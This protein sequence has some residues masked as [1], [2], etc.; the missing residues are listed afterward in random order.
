MNIQE[1]IS[2]SIYLLVGWKF[3]L[4]KTESLYQAH[5]IN[6]PKRTDR[7]LSITR[8]LTDYEIPFRIHKAITPADI[9][10]EIEAVRTNSPLTGI[11][12]P[13]T[14]LDFASG[15]IN[16]LR[17]TLV[18]CL[19][20]HV[21]ILLQISKNQT[22]G[23]VLILEDDAIFL[24]NFYNRTV[25]I[26]GRLPAD[27]DIFHIGF[28]DWAHCDANG[29]QEKDFCKITRS[30]LCCTQ[31]YFVNGWKA[32]ELALNILNT[33]V[34]K[35]IDKVLYQASSNYYASLPKL[36]KQLYAFG[37]DNG[38]GMSQWKE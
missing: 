27:W 16:R 1:I 11:F 3:Q 33:P 15:T 34:P 19:Q 6:L 8:Q 25:D 22:N 10:A 36:A 17:R 35:I 23:P 26:I 12:Q 7:L 30:M 14:K 2:L 38:N 28:C 29:P 37:S 9:D 4:I 18:G 5:V 32:A 20:S 31:A 13:E 21:Q 24:P